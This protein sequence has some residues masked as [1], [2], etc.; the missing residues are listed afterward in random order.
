MR[1][2][3]SSRELLNTITGRVLDEHELV[4]GVAE[5]SREMEEVVRAG[6]GW[7]LPLGIGLSVLELPLEWLDATLEGA[8]V[9]GRT[10]KSSDS[11]A[12]SLSRSIPWNRSSAPS[13]LFGKVSNNGI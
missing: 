4:R 10:T 7:P 13:A 8:A 5:G 1:D 11:F 2:V 12:A 6:V 3:K 9:L